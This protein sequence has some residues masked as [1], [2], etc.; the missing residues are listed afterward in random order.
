MF[1]K[2]FLVALS[3]LLSSCPL[4]SRNM[5][6]T[7]SSISSTRKPDI[8][9]PERH[10]ATKSTI[11]KIQTHWNLHNGTA[12]TC[13]PLG[14]CFPAF[15]PSSF[16]SIDVLLLLVTSYPFKELLQSSSRMRIVIEPCLQKKGRDTKCHLGICYSLD[17]KVWIMKMDRSHA[18]GLHNGGAPR[19]SPKQLQRPLLRLRS[20]SV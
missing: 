7:Y 5:G 8:P 19:I 1:R 3:V 12:E 17:T 13:S 11:R 15:T 4:R 16:S 6:G 9:G 20:Y 14:H 18:I 2:F 10:P